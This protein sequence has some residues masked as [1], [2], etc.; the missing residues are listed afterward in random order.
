MG[1]KETHLWLHTILLLSRICFLSARHSLHM[2]Y[3][4]SHLVPTGL[5]FRFEGISSSP[6]NF[7]MFSIRRNVISSVNLSRTQGNFCLLAVK[8]LKRVNYKRERREKNNRKNILWLRITNK[9]KKE[10]TEKLITRIFA[11]DAIKVNKAFTTS[12]TSQFRFYFN[13]KNCFFSPM[14]HSTFPRHECVFAILETTTG[15][16]K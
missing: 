13:R 11:N 4:S 3:H 15:E 5:G 6:D 8:F 2:R 1:C 12:I 7:N 16:R 9:A 14:I 10:Q